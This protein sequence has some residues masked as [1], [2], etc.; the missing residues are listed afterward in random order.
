MGAENSE[1]PAASAGMTDS[2]AR[3]WRISFCVGMTEVF[4]V[5]MTEVFCAGVVERP[6]YEPP[7]AVSLNGR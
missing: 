3:V 6:V 1:I 5:G 4:C 7:V 2:L